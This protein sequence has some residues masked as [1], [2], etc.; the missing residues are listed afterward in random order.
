MSHGPITG[1]GIM[2]CPKPPQLRHGKHYKQQLRK[3][4]KIKNEAEGTGFIASV[5]GTETESSTIL[6]T[7]GV[8][9]QGYTKTQLVLTLSTKVLSERKGHM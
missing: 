7:L 4:E 2:L 1:W 9:G 3:T 8:L 6:G 5:K